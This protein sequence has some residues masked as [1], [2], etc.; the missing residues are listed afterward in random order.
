MRVRKELCRTLPKFIDLPN[1]KNVS[2]R[3]AEQTEGIDSS[4]GHLSILTLAF[5]ASRKSWT[6][7]CNAL[8]L[9]SA[10]GNNIVSPQNDKATMANGG[11]KQHDKVNQH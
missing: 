5:D 9:C 7:L 8:L 11:T 6:S 3:L 10:E 1:S 4:Q 2:V